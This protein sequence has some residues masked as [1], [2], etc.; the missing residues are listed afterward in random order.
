M[1]IEIN[2]V[3]PTGHDKFPGV[4]CNWIWHDFMHRIKMRNGSHVRT[5]RMMLSTIL[6]PT[7]MMVNAGV[8]H[9]LSLYVDDRIRNFI[10]MFDLKTATYEIGSKSSTM[11]FPIILIG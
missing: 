5:V 4:E 11:K 6:R 8:V 3:T 9:Y 10:D 2:V 1:H 7:L